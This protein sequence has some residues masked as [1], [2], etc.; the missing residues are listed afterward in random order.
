M[1][2]CFANMIVWQIYSAVSKMDNDRKNWG[3]NVVYIAASLPFLILHT[4]SSLI[5]SLPI[6]SSGKKLLQHKQ[7]V[8][9]TKRSKK[10]TFGPCFKRTIRALHQSSLEQAIQRI[11]YYISHKIVTSKFAVIGPLPGCWWATRLS[12]NLQKFMRLIVL[13]IRHWN[14]SYVEAACASL[15]KSW[16]SICKKYRPPVLI[17]LECSKPLSWCVSVAEGIF[18]HQ[19]WWFEFRAVD[20]CDKMYPKT[21]SSSAMLQTFGWQ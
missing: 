15:K 8:L 6:T 17:H 2:F 18:F 16:R 12:R 10:G 3:F 11:N 7:Q 19:F 20:L 1:N 13:M 21:S 9:E 14:L 5:F 4:F